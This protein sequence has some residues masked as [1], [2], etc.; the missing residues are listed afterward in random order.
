MNK[1]KFLNKKEQAAA[2]N[3][4]DLLSRLTIHSASQMDFKAL[5]G[6]YQNIVD[7]AAT[8]HYSAQSLPHLQASAGSSELQVARAGQE[9]PRE[10]A[11]QQ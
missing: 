6:S 3:L 7:A 8:R 9:I 4:L 11:Y 5:A 2:D 1:K 10:T